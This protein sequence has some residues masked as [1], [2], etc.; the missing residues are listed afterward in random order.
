MIS[1]GRTQDGRLVL[2]SNQ[3]FPAPVKHVEYYREQRL[4]SLVFDT[5]DEEIAIMPNEADEKTAD[6]ICASPN[7]MII[8]MAETGAQPYGYM[9]PLIQIG[10]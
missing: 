2:G 10:I 4:F 7:V 3:T 1:L 8:A 9:V 5:Q 6:I